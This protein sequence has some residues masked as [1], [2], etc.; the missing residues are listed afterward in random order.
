MDGQD[1]GLT[2][3]G[4]ADRLVSLER[5]NEWMRLENVKLRDEVAHLRES[6]RRSGVRNH[7]QRPSNCKNTLYE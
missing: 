5:G 2:L 6:Y 4:L 1:G 7:W 3:Q